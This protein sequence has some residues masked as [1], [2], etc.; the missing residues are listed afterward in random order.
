[1]TVAPYLIRLP[2]GLLRPDRPLK[3]T[4]PNLTRVRRKGG[5]RG[6]QAHHLRAVLD[7]LD[8]P[9]RRTP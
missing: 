8:R 2:G 9:T 3:G 6:G 1:M 7:R 5:H 4:M